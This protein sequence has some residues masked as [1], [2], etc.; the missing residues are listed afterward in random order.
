MSSFNKRTDGPPFAPAKNY[1]TVLFAVLASGLQYATLLS[2]NDQT[3]ISPQLGEI[4]N[5]ADKKHTNMKETVPN[6]RFDPTMWEIYLL[7]LARILGGFSHMTQFLT[8]DFGLFL[9]KIC[10]NQ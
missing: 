9:K 10:A 2:K 3:L 6:E 5:V 7:G 4:S 8:S 1:E